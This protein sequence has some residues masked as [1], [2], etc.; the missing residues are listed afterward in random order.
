MMDQFCSWGGGKDSCLAR[1]RAERAG[2]PLPLLTMIVEAGDG[3]HHGYTEAVTQ[4]AKSLGTSVHTETVTW[5][6]YEDRFTAAIADLDGSVGVFGTI[7]VEAHRSWV[8]S[9]CASVGVSP[10]FPLWGEDPVDLFHEILDRGWE[11]I[12]VKLDGAVIDDCW[13]G[14]PLDAAF[15][16]HLLDSDIHPMGEGGEYQTLVVDGPGFTRRVPI[17]VRGARPAGTY[18]VGRLA[19]G[20]RGEGD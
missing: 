10:R 3:R 8:E 18:R 4:Q 5:G 13:L 15:L 20:A 16:D 14:Q 12:V 11:A 2:G 9:A 19:V 17:E 1:S 7:D 6:T